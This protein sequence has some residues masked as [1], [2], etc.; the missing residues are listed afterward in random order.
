MEEAE[1]DELARDFERDGFVNAGLALSASETAEVVADLER[2]MDGLFRGGPSVLAPGYAADLGHTK[3]GSH[4]QIAAMWKASEPFRR[5]IESKRIA[6][7]GARLLGSRTIQLWIDTVQYK[8][9]LRGGPFNWHQDAP[10][11]QS[12]EPPHR[13]IGAW[14][15]LDDADEE[16][17]CMWMVPGSHRWGFQEPHLWTFHHNT[18]PQSFGKVTP[19][20]APAID[21]AEWR[22][23]EPCRVRAGEVHFH[24]AYTWHGSPTNHTNRPRRGYSMFLMAEDVRASHTPDPRIKLPPGSLMLEAGWDFPILYRAAEA[25]SGT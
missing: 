9:P 14:V 13:L 2:Y 11:H 15:A 1:L 5:V 22:G 4:Y 12:I 18:D 16:S 19:P 6:E 20:K 3:D 7:V 10:Y 21:A 17:G 23:A 24:H 25:A 8:P